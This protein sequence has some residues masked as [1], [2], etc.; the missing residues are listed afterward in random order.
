MN[1]EMYDIPYIP[2]TPYKINIY[3]SIIVLCVASFLILFLVRARKETKQKTPYDSTEFFVERCSRR[4]NERCVVVVVLGDR[5]M[6]Y[7][8]NTQ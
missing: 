4:F 1:Y 7:D 5:I 2:Y 8:H 3:H 6:G